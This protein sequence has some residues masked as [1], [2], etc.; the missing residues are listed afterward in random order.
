MKYFLL[1]FIIVGCTSKNSKKIFADQYGKNWPFIMDKGTLRCENGMVIFETEGNDY[2]V[3]GFAKT[4]YP[5]DI[6][7]I[8][9]DDKEL[10]TPFKKDIEQIID[11]G[12]KLCK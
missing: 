9:Q 6:T 4:S 12:L 10:G 11:D 1:L 3:N 8:L 2:G 7:S 5:N